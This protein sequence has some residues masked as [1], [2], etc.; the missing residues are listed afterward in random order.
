MMQLD[1]YLPFYYA[2]MQSHIEEW[3]GNKGY[4]GIIDN[5]EEEECIEQFEYCGHEASQP[6]WAAGRD[7]S[8]R[9]KCVL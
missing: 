5:S 3:Y 9:R 1:P 7:N 4:L 8:V 2:E 6:V